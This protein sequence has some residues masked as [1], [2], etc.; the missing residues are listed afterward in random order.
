M[1]LLLI[2]LQKINHSLRLT[3]RDRESGLWDDLSYDYMSAFDFDIKFDKEDMLDYHES[4]MNHAMVL[5]GVNI[6]E[7]VPNRWK[8]EN[9]WG[10]DSGNKG[11]YMMSGSWFDSYV[12][13]AV[14]NK[15]YLSKEELDALKGTLTKLAPWD[16]MGTL[17]D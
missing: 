5:T 15:K 4:C 14:I 9:S 12:Y 2:R 16:P 10:P 6:K 11:Y 3:H 13:Q 7:G 8:I 1:S 17:A